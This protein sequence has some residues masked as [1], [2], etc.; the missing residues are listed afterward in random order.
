MENNVFNVVYIS[1]LLAF[2]FSLHIR[3]INCVDVEVYVTGFLLVLIEKLEKISRLL[4]Y[5]S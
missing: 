4:Y 1:R 5:S 2:R 3:F